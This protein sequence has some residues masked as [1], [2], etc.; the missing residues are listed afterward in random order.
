MF[1]A[2]VSVKKAF[3]AETSVTILAEEVISNLVD[4]LVAL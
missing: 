3:F 1:L 4:T 2:S